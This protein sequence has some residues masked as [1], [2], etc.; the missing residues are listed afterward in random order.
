MVLSTNREILQK[1]M[2]AAAEH[3]ESELVDKIFEN[4]LCMLQ[5]PGLE[6]LDWKILNNALKDLCNGFNAFAPYRQKRKISIFGSARLTPDSKVYQM[7]RAFAALMSQKG[8]MTITGGGGGVMQAG[9]EGA[10]RDMSFGLNIVL[11]DFQDTNNFILDDPKAVDFKYFFTR[12]LF[13]M[14]ETDALALFPGGFG[15]WDEAFE[16]MT[17]IQTGK[18]LIMPIVLVEEPG[19]DYWKEWDRMLHKLL[20]SRGLVDE[21]DLS[22]YRRVETIDQACEE[23]M[24]FYRVYHSSRYLGEKFLIRIN[25]LLSPES[26]ETLSAEFADFLAEP[27]YQ[28]QQALPKEED[29]LTGQLPRLILLPK[30]NR[31][32]RLRIF[33]DRL[34][35][36]GD[37]VNLDPTYR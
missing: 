34:N 12:K 28:T 16:C 15:T 23:V 19:G 26:L 20:G 35:Q 7:A 37:S 31:P 21:V 6:R 3:P 27:V 9:N 36:L 8:F 14:R 32:G 22:L 18:A 5:N 2:E 13:F 33:I 1:L 29:T 25:T 30:R 10:G 24:Q 17:L 4:L 11:P